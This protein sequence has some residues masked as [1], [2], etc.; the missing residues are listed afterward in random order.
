MRGVLTTLVLAFAI[1]FVLV[2]TP[3]PLSASVPESVPDQTAQG[4]EVPDG[5][6]PPIVGQDG[7]EG[8]PDDI[9]GGFR[10]LEGEQGHGTPGGR[11]EMIE[12]KMLMAIIEQ[13]VQLNLR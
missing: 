10:R 8:D 12:L 7:A 2:A 4:L 13:L 9:G 6:P 11:S 1:V 5:G 3:D